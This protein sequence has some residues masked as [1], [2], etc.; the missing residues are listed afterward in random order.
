MPYKMFVGSN[1]PLVKAYV[2]Y[3][4]IV[5]STRLTALVPG[6]LNREATT[7]SLFTGL[8][9]QWDHT[10]YPPEHFGLIAAGLLRAVWSN[11]RMINLDKL[12]LK[13]GK[14]WTRAVRRIPGRPAD[15][16]SS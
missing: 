5:T 10:T 16:A 3:E 6:L 14:P 13:T 8:M 12:R 9:Y 11:A 4:S 1:T 7:F 2:P 15:R